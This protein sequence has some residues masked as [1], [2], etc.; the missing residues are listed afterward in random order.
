M[1]PA[2]FHR[3]AFDQFTTPFDRVQAAARR[4][5]TAATHMVAMALTADELRAA[6]AA[7]PAHDAYFLAREIMLTSID[8]TMKEPQK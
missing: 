5:A 8:R 3:P 4:N 6:F 7:L 1:T 2:G